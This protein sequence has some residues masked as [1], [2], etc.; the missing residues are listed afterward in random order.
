M[1]FTKVNYE[2]SEQCRICTLRNV[3]L[4]CVEKCRE[5]KYKLCWRLPGS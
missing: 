2:E 1:Y 3:T 4:K 5:A